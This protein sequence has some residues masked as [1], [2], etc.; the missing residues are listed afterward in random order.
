MAE[1]G[2]VLELYTEKVRADTETSPRA[3]MNLV[4]MS[5]NIR[6]LLNTMKYSQSKSMPC[7]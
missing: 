5:Y 2:Q 4:Y 7:L 3:D 6:V 1:A